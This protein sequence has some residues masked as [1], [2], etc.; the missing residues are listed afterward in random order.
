[1]EASQNKKKGWKLFSVRRSKDSR[2]RPSMQ[3]LEPPLQVPV[4]TVIPIPG[5]HQE[6]AFDAE[7]R[8]AESALK[9]KSSNPL[10]SGDVQHVEAQLGDTTEPEA[11]PPGDK[12]SGE[13]ASTRRTL[14][15]QNFKNAV[16]KLE[17]L[18]PN[19]SNK[20]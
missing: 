8:M 5:P 18:M 20:K 13:S 15:L 6:L 17:K 19:E 4:P 1:M 9:V 7:T 12:P 2:R 16:D 14:A 11:N 3:L 10:H